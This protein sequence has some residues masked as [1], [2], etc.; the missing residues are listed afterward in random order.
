MV[1]N[2]LADKE[3]AMLTTE[4]EEQL[5]RSLAAFDVYYD[6]LGGALVGFVER[7]GMQ[8]AHEVLGNAAEYLP[9]IDAAMRTIAIRD[10]SWQWVKTMLG[11]FLGE[12][13]VQTYAGCWYVETRP[14]SPHF[15]RTMVGGFE[16]GL[17][18]DAAIEP[19]ALALAFLAEALPRELARL[20][21]DTEAGL[22]GQH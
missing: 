19:E 2:N 14:Q 8:P 10:E 12:Y 9:Y 3:V 6:E 18:L 7:L 21:S 17:P 4:Q 16:T 15:C 22:A 1:I 13:F 11:Y 5:Q 20:V